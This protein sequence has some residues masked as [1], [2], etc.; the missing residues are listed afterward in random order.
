MIHYKNIITN[1]YNKSEERII[2]KVELGRCD[3]DPL[4]VQK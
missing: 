4:K 2:T 1:K 3:K